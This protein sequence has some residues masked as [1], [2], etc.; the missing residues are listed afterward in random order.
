MPMQKN[1]STLF[2]SSDR[3]ANIGKLAEDRP[4]W[5]NH[6]SAMQKAYNTVFHLSKDSAK[7]DSKKDDKKTQPEKSMDQYL[8]SLITLAESCYKAEM[9]LHETIKKH[10]NPE[11]KRYKGET[12]SPLPVHG[13]KR[14]ASWEY[15]AAE[16]QKLFKDFLEKKPEAAKAL[17]E[18]LKHNNG[19]SL[20]EKANRFVLA[21][22]PP[23]SYRR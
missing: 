19:N 4:T 9:F 6:F 1:L 5:N 3:F 2:D 20:Y 12:P 16:Y 11:V 23:T 7:S 21:H 22:R 10:S 14:L 17:E 15:V 18:K 13:I 8:D